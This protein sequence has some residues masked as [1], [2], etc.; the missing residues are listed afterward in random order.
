MYWLYTRTDTKNCTRFEHFDQH[1]AQW[2]VKF[3]PS[4]HMCAWWECEAHCSFSPSSQFPGY[5][6]GCFG[7]LAHVERGGTSFIRLEL[8]SKTQGKGFKWGPCTCVFTWV[9]HAWPVTVSVWASAAWR[10]PLH[11]SFGLMSSLHYLIWQCVLT[12]TSALSVWYL[13]WPCIYSCLRSTNHLTYVTGRKEQK[14]SASNWILIQTSRIFVFSSEKFPE[15]TVHWSHTKILA[16][17]YY[18]C[19]FMTYY[20][21]WEYI[22]LDHPACSVETFQKTVHW[23]AKPFRIQ[24]NTEPKECSHAVSRQKEL[25]Q[26]GFC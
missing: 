7:K 1:F 12:D 22:S 13:F 9:C 20:G 4:V 2:L 15:L 5:P 24:Q 8:T 25:Y 10:T 16:P 14:E 21:R 26:Y 3:L 18:S 11:W 19:Y 23:A 17:I 6:G